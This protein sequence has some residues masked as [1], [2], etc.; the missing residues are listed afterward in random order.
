S[1]AARYW[2]HN[3][4]A[5]PR[6][7]EGPASCGLAAVRIFVLQIWHEISTGMDRTP[8]EVVSKH[9]TGSLPGA[10]QTVFAGTWCRIVAAGGRL[11][12]SLP[13][14]GRVASG[15]RPRIKGSGHEIGCGSGDPSGVRRGPCRS[16][17]VPATRSPP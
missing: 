7:G 16:G 6:N 2:H 11:E 3:D 17:S 10:R 14:R 4:A 8:Y 1:S 9:L 5:L 15:H 12:G 13:A